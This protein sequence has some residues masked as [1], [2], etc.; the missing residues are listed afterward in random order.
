METKSRYE[1]IAEL[2]DKKSK[3]LSQQ[4]N[5]GLNE[6]QYKIGVQKAQEQLDD[7]L[8]QKD[9]VAQNIKDQLESLEKSL[10]RLNSQKK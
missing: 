1:I 3:L 8:S 9:I 5:L 4:A 6:S 7:F 2:E 10:E